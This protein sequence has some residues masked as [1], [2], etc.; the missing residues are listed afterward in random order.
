MLILDIVAQLLNRCLDD[1]HCTT[2]GSIGTGAASRTHMLTLYI[3][4]YTRGTAAEGIYRC[5]WDPVTG[6]FTDLALAVAAD[7]PSFLLA[8]RDAVFAVHECGDYQRAPTDAA[9]AT[10]AN[11]GSGEPRQGAVSQYLIDGKAL[12]CI[13]RVGSG[14]A[15]PCH[16]AAREALI[17][18]ANYTGGSVALL[19]L[20]D[21]QLG[22]AARVLQFKARGPHP[23]QAD[24][25]P[26]GVYFDEAELLAPD[27][28]ADRIHRLDPAT[29]Y[30]RGAWLVEAGSG[31]RHLARSGTGVIYLLSE[32]T[33]RID[34]LID[35]K[36][37]Q[38]VSTLPAGADV[39]SIGAEIALT[40]DGRYLLASN[41]GHDSLVRFAVDPRTGQL[42]DPAFVACGA[43][44]RHFAVIGAWVVIASR[45]SNQ[46]TALRLDTNGR[47][48][49]IGDL[50][51]CPA[52]VCVLASPATPGSAR[53]PRRVS[54]APIADAPPH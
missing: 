1:R 27:L 50:I 38:S 32:L 46:L 45:D 36:W 51:A 10:T 24:A 41:R 54:P 17:A 18:V 4:T 40:P 25:H 13:A 22:P 26:H 30:S 29:G 47:F 9:S 16:L 21:G 53:R 23:R 14:G 37:V 44:P 15:D 5:R 8:H 35:G 34:V 39:H 11:N 2:P 42:G 19:P 12:R 7:N 33:N 52:P 3:G 49:E 43:H 31:P 6:R 48:G 28:G 20:H